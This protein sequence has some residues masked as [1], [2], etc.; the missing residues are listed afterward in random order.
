M[1]FQPWPVIIFW[2]LSNVAFLVLLYF[3][4]RK[5]WNKSSKKKS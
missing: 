5:Y 3:I 4:L 2:L 1:E